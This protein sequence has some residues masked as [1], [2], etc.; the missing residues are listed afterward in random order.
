MEYPFT[1]LHFCF[2]GVET[3]A[4]NGASHMVQIRINLWTRSNLT[5]PEPGFVQVMAIHNGPVV[6]QLGH[7]NDYTFGAVLHAVMK[8]GNHGRYQRMIQCAKLQ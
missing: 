4:G 3:R 7:T 1:K 6:L 5:Q 8:H 2:D